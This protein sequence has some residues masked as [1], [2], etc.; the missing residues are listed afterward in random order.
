MRGQAHERV[1][2]FTFGHHVMAVNNI[3]FEL[4]FLR[5]VATITNTVASAR[6]TSAMPMMAAPVPTV[7]ASSCATESDAPNK[8]NNRVWPPCGKRKH[9]HSRRQLLAGTRV[10]SCRGVPYQ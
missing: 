9:T 5:E 3:S 6:A 7:P 10:C 2:V 4:N 8:A 1:V